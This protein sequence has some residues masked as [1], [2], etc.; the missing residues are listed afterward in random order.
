ME[1]PPEVQRL[2][3]PHHRHTERRKNRPP[4][5][6]SISLSTRADSRTSTKERIEEEEREEC[7]WN[8]CLA[9]SLGS[10]FPSFLFSQ[11]DRRTPEEKRLWNWLLEGEDVD[12]GDKGDAGEEKKTRNRRRR[13]EED[14]SQIPSGVLQVETQV[15]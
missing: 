8:S 15:R 12:A 5:Q 14:S 10:V 6:A 13:G 9:R 2:P 4:W 7:R 11:D 3:H 1:R